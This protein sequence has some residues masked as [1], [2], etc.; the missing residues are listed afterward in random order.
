MH[1]IKLEASNVKRLTAVKITPQG[2]VVKITGKNDQGKSSVLDSIWYALGGVEN[3]PEDPIRAGADEAKIMLDLGEM[4]VTRKMRR[5]EDATFTSS[6]IVE[7]K[8]GTRP[9]SPQTLLNEL[10]GKFTLDPLAFSRLPPKGQFDALKMLVPGLDLDAMK[11]ANDTDY[12]KRTAE[13]RRAKEALAAAAA[14]QVPEEKVE[15]VDEAPILADMAK[16]G[17]HNKGIQDQAQRRKDAA[18][19]VETLQKSNEDAREEIDRLTK[20]IEILKST[21]SSDEGTVQILTKKLA[22]AA[23]LAEPLDTVKLSEALVAAR[24]AN[25]IADKQALRDGYRKTAEGHEKA[26]EALT[27]S[28]KARDEE[29]NAAISKA[30]FPVEGLSLGDEEV[31]INGHPFNQ[32]AS[33][34]KIKTSVALAMAADPQIRVLRIMDGSL[35]DSEAMKV[36]TDMAEEKDFQVWIEAVSEGNGAGIVIEDGHVKS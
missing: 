25:D 11:A 30:K 36:I 3:I 15:K 20:M 12:E 9:K 35:L 24:A 17:D 31:L 34:Q 2:K 21:I 26:A 16:A 22:E 19:R 7:N 18:A 29:K 27:E 10:V 13:N 32:A 14:I 8:D 1:I 23:P 6:L 28:M 4:T 5:K 33:S